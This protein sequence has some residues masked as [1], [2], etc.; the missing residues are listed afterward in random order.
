MGLGEKKTPNEFC[1][2]HHL[3]FPEGESV[4][5]NIDPTLCTVHYTSFDE[6]IQMVQDMGKG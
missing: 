6:A 3:S 2:I 1:L 4:N 5:D